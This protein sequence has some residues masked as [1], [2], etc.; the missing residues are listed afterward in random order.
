MDKY[1]YICIYKNIFACTHTYINTYTQK[2]KHAHMVH[3]LAS[4]TYRL[5][6]HHRN[7]FSRIP[8]KKKVSH[9]FLFFSLYNYVK[10]KKQ[11]N[12]W[13]QRLRVNF[14]LFIFTKNMS[15]IARNTAFISIIGMRLFVC[16]TWR[17]QICLC[18]NLRICY[19]YLWD[20]R[21]SFNIKKIFIHEGKSWCFYLFVIWKHFKIIISIL[22]SG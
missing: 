18:K 8:K 15:S 14:Q 5:V 10:A 22:L 3:F 7:L 16:Y 9:C 13:P 2:Q 11:I 6:R 12:I 1:I 21:E 17:S 19:V 20:Q 4:K